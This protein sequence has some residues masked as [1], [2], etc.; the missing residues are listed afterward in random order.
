LQAVIKPV[1][2]FADERP[3]NRMAHV[4]QTL[5]ELAKALGSPQQRRLRIAS[6]LWLDQRAQIIE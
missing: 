6:R 3:A 5:A 1:Q 4:A 2:E